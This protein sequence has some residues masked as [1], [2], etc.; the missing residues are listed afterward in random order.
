MKNLSLLLPGPNQRDVTMW[1]TVTSVT[2][3]RIRLDGESTAL[4]MTPDTLVAGLVISDRVWVTFAVNAEP[5]FAGRRAVILGVSGGTPAPAPPPSQFRTVADLTARNALT[6][7]YNGYAV[8]RE[9][10]KGLNV[11][12]GSGWRYLVRPTSDSVATL[13]TTGNTAYTALATAGPA[14][15]VET[16]STAQV[17]VTAFLFN[18]GAGFVNFMGYAVSGATTIAASDDRALQLHSEAANG[19]GRMSMTHLQTGL[20]PG[21]NVFTARYRVNAGAG[22]WSTRVITVE[23]K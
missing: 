19:Q 6:G 13:D 21:D 1:A 10:L 2:P 16:G 17:T 15:T 18:S 3:L 22:G 4:A 20:T 7:L 14:V 8:W 9:D 11:Y 23:P 5:G 12:D